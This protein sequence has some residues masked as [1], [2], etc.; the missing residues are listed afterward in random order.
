M[1]SIIL[2]AYNEEDN[3]SLAIKK[4]S[5]VLEPENIDFELIFV[6]DGSKDNTWQN[7]LSAHKKTSVCMVCRSAEISARNRQCLPD[8]MWQTAIASP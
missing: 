8:L 6:N 5:A 7:I 1:L 3:I 4:V 2:P